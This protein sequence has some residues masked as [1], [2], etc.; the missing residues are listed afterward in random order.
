LGILSDRLAGVRPSPTVAMATRAQELRRAGRDV[1]ALAAGEPDF[2]TPENIRDAAK[3]AI[4]TG[5]TRYTAPDGMPELKSAIAEKFR[6][7]NGLVFSA[8]EICVGA[9]GKHVLWNALLATLNPGDEVV[10]PA[11]YWVSYPDMTRLA[12]GTPVI[13]QTTAAAGYRL[14]PEALEAAITPRT[15]W[16]IVNSPGN[17]TGAGYDAAALA[18]LAAVLERHPQ[19]WVMSDDIYEHV[20]YPPFRFATIAQVAPALAER[21]LTVNGVS[22]AYAMTGWRIGY[23]GGP[24]TLIAAMRKVQSQSTTNPATISQWAAV[25]ALEGPQDYIETARAAFRRRRDRVAAALDACPGLACPLPE[26]AFYLFASVED[27]LGRRT[28]AGR[29][30]STDEDFAAALLDETGVAVVP[31]SAFGGGPAF[32]LS[33]AAADAA[34]DEACARIAGFC[35]TLR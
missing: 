6:R 27:T 10:I 32:R 25:E 26:G 12:G 35:N 16:L 28:R 11:P 24:E 9:G 1:I 30:M 22:K 20:A 19:V 8:D 2:D 17:P 15:K 34:L 21:T 14:S 5:H 23:A 13:V 31:G 7:E 29:R 18:G 4:D 3:R 33:Y